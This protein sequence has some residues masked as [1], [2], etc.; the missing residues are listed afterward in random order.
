MTLSKCRQILEQLGVRPSKSLGQNF[1]VDANILPIIVRAAD[2]RPDETVVEIGPG[3]GILTAALE[4]TV[5]KKLI[6]IEKDARLADFLRE[7]FPKI[8]L[9]IGDALEFEPPDGPY[10]VVSNLPYSMSTAILEKFAEAERKPRAMVLMLQREVAER[11]AAPPRTKAYGPLALFTQLFYHPTVVHIVSPQCFFPAPD[12]ESAIVLLERRDPRERLQNG[13]PF[14]ELVRK[15]FSQRRKMLRK[16]LAEY[17]EME[18]ILADLGVSST[19]RAEELSLEQWILLAN[20]LRAAR[21]D[22]K[23]PQKRNARH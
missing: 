17:S 8:E 11:L 18:K 3:L 21:A 16:M 6:A 22:D 12:V 7:K 20:R 5:A 19:A 10:K 14:H 1:L 13:A 15:G 2:I 4:K 23:K 9:R